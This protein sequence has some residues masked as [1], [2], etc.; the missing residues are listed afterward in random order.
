MLDGVTSKPRR[1]QHEPQPN[2]TRIPDRFSPLFAP[3]I[4]DENTVTPDKACKESESL[5]DVPEDCTSTASA[6][7]KESDYRADRPAYDDQSAVS[8]IKP[9]SSE[10]VNLRSKLGCPKRLKSGASPATTANASTYYTLEDL[11][12]LGNMIDHQ[13]TKAF[14]SFREQ[15][16]IAAEDSISYFEQDH[17]IRTGLS[18]VAPSDDVRQTLETRGELELG[19][20]SEI[21]GSSNP[22]SNGAGRSAVDLTKGLS[23]AAHC[24]RLFESTEAMGLPHLSSP[25]P[26][27]P[28]GRSAH[29]NPDRWDKDESRLARLRPSNKPPDPFEDFGPFGSLGKNPDER[30]RYRRTVRTA[31][32]VLNPS[33]VLPFWYNDHRLALEPRKLQ[34][35]RANKLY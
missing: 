5:K 31:S 24:S 7:E 22:E 32:G 4:I 28:R 19:P 6:Q 9:L 13:R 29:P 10:Y 20:S 35:W 8:G 12:S 30:F 26:W 27:G 11:K 1:I 34:F 21:F 17:I 2:F 25:L 3:S 23:D 18:L 16:G 14:A 15:R 33:T